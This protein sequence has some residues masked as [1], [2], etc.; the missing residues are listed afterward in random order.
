METVIYDLFIEEMENSGFVRV[1][2]KIEENEVE[3]AE[4]DEAIYIKTEHLK[5]CN[6][7]SIKGIRESKNENKI[8]ERPHNIYLKIYDYDRKEARPEDA[9]RFAI[10]GTK[11]STG[12]SSVIYYHYPY[13]L[14]SSGKFIGIKKGMMITKDEKLEIKVIRG[15][16]PIKIGKFE[17][18]IEC[19]KWYS[20]R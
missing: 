19:D 2:S 1:P 15:K 17:L 9:I 16:E 3:L 20:K 5:N 7:F 10:I 4:D 13:E 18:I 6:A 12:Q 14:L 8:V 11:R